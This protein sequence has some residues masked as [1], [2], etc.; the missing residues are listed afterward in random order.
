[1]KAKNLF[2]LLGL[3]ALFGIYLYY[4]VQKP[5]EM[6][7]SREAEENKIFTE[8]PSKLQKIRIQNASQTTELEKRGENWFI[9]N[10]S[11]DIASISKMDNLLSSLERLKRQKTIA[12]EAS[13]KEGKTT[14]SSFGLD[15]A[16]LSLFYTI[17]GKPE[18][19]IRM[20]SQN[21]S[22]S[23]VYAH[24]SDQKDVVLASTDLD[25]LNSQVADDFREMKL[26][27]VEAQDYSDI[28][29]EAK[30]EKIKLARNAQ[31]AWEMLEPQKL[32]LDKEFTN[33]QAEKVSYLRVNQFLN[34]EPQALKKPEIKVSVQFKGEK[35]DLR[36]GANDSRPHG[37][38]FLLSKSPKTKKEA[39]PVDVKT[40]PGDAFDYFAKSDKSQP[41]TLARF[42]FD[43]FTKSYKDYVRKTF[44][45]FETSDIQ[46]WSLNVP[47]ANSLEG[48]REGADFT[49]K[50]GSSDGKVAASHLENIFKRFRNARATAF[51][52][53]NAPSK[54]AWVLNLKL[55]DGSQR[56]F[57]GLIEG[58]HLS[59][60][61]D[62]GSYKLHYS[63]PSQAL[64]VKDFEWTKLIPPPAAS[65][66]TD[67][68][69]AHAPEGSPRQE[70]KKLDN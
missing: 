65:T 63:L 53:T 13:I 42:H 9:T 35:K 49:I 61:Y 33:G 11:N 47:G 36:S 50:Q 12:S 27:T 21:P 31:D 51:L 45:S 2:V 55:Q 40:D 15:P 10:P 60:W 46:S 44:D 64:D 34:D 23:G 26:T 28:L 29:I 68:P 37:A 32:P 67:A 56:S 70:E 8:A 1:M 58:D 52:D 7:E 17:E 59:L 25:Y 19:F 48:K 6:K 54:K 4:G 24:T 14:L 41:G 18:A 20:G 57:S 16:K 3:T 30:G 62:D 69:Q 38:L 22:G 5:S 43:N 39:K 66:K